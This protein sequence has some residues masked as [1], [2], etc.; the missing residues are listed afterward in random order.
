MKRFATAL[1]LAFTLTASA[2]AEVSPGDDGSD[3]RAVL[4]SYKQAIENLDG[5]AA[6][7]L[8]AAEAHIFE[9]GGDEGSWAFYLEHHLEPEFVELKSFR[10]SDYK[11]EVE[12]TGDLAIASETY[13]YTIELKDS[14][15]TIVRLGAATSVLRR[16]ADGWK[17]ILYHSS[18]RKTAG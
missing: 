14:V 4:Q 7:G 15:E 1:L 9:Q 12:V 3:V 8:F 10:F 5:V 13:G 18:S 2:A 16:T 17:I 6:S 11:V